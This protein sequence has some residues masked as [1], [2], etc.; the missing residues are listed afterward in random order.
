MKANTGSLQGIKVIDLSRVLGGPFCTQVLADH[1]AEVIKIEPPS[2]DE[3]RLWGPPFQDGSAAYFAGVNRNKQGLVLDLRQAEGQA[4]L[5]TLLA[6]ADVLVENFKI[7]TLEKWGLGNPDAL[8]SA[9]PRL[10]HCRISGFGADGPLGGLP[11]YDS[12]IQAMTGIMSMNGEA[13][14][15]PLRVGLPVVDMVTGLNASIGILL[16]LQARQHS[17]RGQFVEAALY[18]SGVS[19]LHPHI[20]N[21]LMSGQV[22]GRSGNAHPN[23]A[24]YDVY[25]TAT[26][27]IYIAVGNNAQFAKLCRHIGA[28]VLL[29]DERFVDNARRCAHR[30][31]LKQD[32]E[33]FLSQFKG[34]ELAMALIQEGV[35]CGP[36]L[37]V[38]DV[39][40]H[41]H[42]A[43]RQMLVSMGSDYRGMGSPIKL[44]HS[45]ASYRSPPP[46]F[47]GDSIEVL[48]RHGYDAATINAFIKK[49]VV[50]TT[51]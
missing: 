40:E 17:G 30:V 33:G 46:R 41:P 7:G 10:I 31:A 1:G 44:S 18:D 16:A 38:A 45:P 29:E 15:T 23:I 24:P 22:P 6:D 21:Y 8:A 35:P 14:G 11:G 4:V 19:L 27:P 34:P 42:T 13:E 50:Q 37:T 43:H 12:V 39:V 47:G 32:L 25:A 36:I 9:F 5:R 28:G 2:G 51:D 20:P 49:G 26:D 48:Q 3:T